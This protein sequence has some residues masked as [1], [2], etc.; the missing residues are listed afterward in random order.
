MTDMAPN[1]CPSCEEPLD[2]HGYCNN[3]DCSWDPEPEEYDE[4]DEDLAD[5]EAEEDDKPV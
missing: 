5:S 2:E 4:T 1:K 3:L